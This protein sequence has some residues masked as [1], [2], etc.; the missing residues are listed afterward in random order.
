MPLCPSGGLPLLPPLPPTS[1]SLSTRPAQP[2]PAASLR[3]QAEGEQQQEQQ[4]Q[5]GASEEY[6]AAVKRLTALLDER[7][8]QYEFSDIEVSLEG[9]GGQHT[10]A[11]AGIVAYRWVVPCLHMMRMHGDISP[12]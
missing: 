9:E 11:A 12:I 5:Q 2:C 7:R 3:P 8:K 10:G 1:L 4:Q 6:A